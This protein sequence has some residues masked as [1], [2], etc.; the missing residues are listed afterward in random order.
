[1]NKYDLTVAFRP[2][3]D[4]EANTEKLEE[5]LEKTVAVLGGKTGKMTEMG[6]KQLAYKIDNLAEAT[7]LNWTLELPGE[8]VV[9]L[10][11]KLTIDR[12]IIRHLLVKG[13]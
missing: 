10:E 1:M 8:A 7:F 13:T 11:K 5:K 9:Q 12:D 3:A 4:G 2:A 6:R